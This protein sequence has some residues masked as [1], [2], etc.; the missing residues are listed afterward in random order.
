MIVKTK[1]FNMKPMSDEEAL[2]QLEL[3]GHDF[4]V[5][6]NAESD[7]V[8]V[9][10]KRRDGNYGLIEADP[11]M[12][13]AR[14]LMPRPE[15]PAS[16]GREP[17]EG[18]GP[19]V[20]GSRPPATSTMPPYGPNHHLGTIQITMSVFQKILRAGEGRTLKRLEQRVREVNALEPEVERLSDEQLRRK[21][22]RV[23]CPVR[24][25]R[26][27]RRPAGRGLRVRSRGGQAHH[28]HA[29]VRRSAGRRHGAA[30]G[31]DRRDED[32]RGQDA[33]RHAAAVPERD[34]GRQR[35]PGDRQRLPRPPR[36]HVDAA[37]L[38]G[39]GSHRGRDPV[40]HARRR[41]AVRKAA[42]ACDITYGTN[43]EFGFDYLRDNMAADLA[44]TRCS[45]A[46]TSRSSTR[47]TRS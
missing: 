43:S 29:P 44:Q 16:G 27:P 46:T 47:S 21:D 28:R 42:Y 26:E 12:M 9:I 10:Y 14:N 2:L 39:P 13:C 7:E 20:A 4:F 1:Q 19:T 3:I 23:P 17:A 24:S 8:N 38:R 5:F 15:G 40:E 22:G 37:D 18:A 6:V 11:R 31:P 25:G 36:R 41:G 45:A 32:R 35:A 34:G 33:G 30:R